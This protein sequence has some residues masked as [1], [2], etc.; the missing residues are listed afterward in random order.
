MIFT[1]EL[2]KSMN[3]IE[4]EWDIFLFAFNAIKEDT[5]LDIIRTNPDESE[6]R[7]KLYYLTLAINELEKKLQ[8]CV[9]SC[10]DIKGNK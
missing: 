5:A 2:K 4:R 7:E 6:K 9:N 1:D 3:V 8:D 10:H